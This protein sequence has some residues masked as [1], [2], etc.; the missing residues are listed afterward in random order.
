MFKTFEFRIWDLF[1]IWSLLFAVSMPAQAEYRC[2]LLIGNSK[3]PDAALASPA[4]DVKAMAEVFRKRGFTVTTVEDLS[5]NDA[6]EAVEKFADT[7]P[8]LGTAVVYFSG[9]A[10]Q[11]EHNGNRRDNYFLGLDGV[12]K[13]SWEVAR[14]EVGVKSVLNH[15]SGFGGSHTKIVIVE[16]CYQHPQQDQETARGLLKLEDLP[17]NSMVAYAARLGEVA[18]PPKNGVAP[19]TAKLAKQ[20]ADTSRSLPDCLKATASYRVTNLPGDDKLRQPGSSAISPPTAFAAGKKVGDEWVNRYGM[21]FCW[22]PPGTVLMGSPVDEKGRDH[23]EGPVEVTISDGFWISKYELT[24]DNFNVITRSRNRRASDDKSHPASGHDIGSYRRT[25]I[26]S[27]NAGE[28]SKGTLPG[29]WDY[30]LPTEAQWEY[31]ARA[32]TQTAHYFGNKEDGLPRHGNFA[33]LSLFERGQG[34]PVYAH[35]SL[36]DGMVGL[37]RVGQYLPNPWGLHDVYG[38]MWE[39][40]EDAYRE[41]L[42]GGADP[43]IAITPKSQ[44]M[45]VVRG[46]CWLSP[47]NYCRSAF[48]HRFILTRSREFV[49]DTAGC[50]LVIRPIQ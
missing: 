41:Q 9:Y 33:D 1:V 39:W 6:K 24:Q 25:V 23:D 29:N 16:G 37:G 3:Y 32:G 50:R 44:D 42:P 18:V 34:Y 49:H 21:V 4:A 14:S 47:S 7:V 31:A 28:R 2:A 13:N 10:L 12:A 26:D 38:N 8:V 36:D 40:C 19:F 30:A 15:L 48:R 35:R 22:C 11:G 5:G 45:Q 17:A 46:G 20:L 27:L 43:R